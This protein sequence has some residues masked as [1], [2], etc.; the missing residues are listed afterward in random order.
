MVCIVLDI[1]EWERLLPLTRFILHRWRMKLYW[2]KRD[3]DGI[4]QLA[5][6]GIDGFGNLCVEKSQVTSNMNQMIDMNAYKRVIAKI[7]FDC[8][9]EVR[10]RGYVIWNL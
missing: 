5:P 8:L 10:G 7:A 2:D 6:S 1:S 9:A 4:W 3:I